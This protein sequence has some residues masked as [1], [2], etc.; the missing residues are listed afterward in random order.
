M[1][2]C[3]LGKSNWTNQTSQYANK[4]ALFKGKIF[5]FRAYTKRLDEGFID[6]SYD[7]GKDKLA[8]K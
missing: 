7:W 8:L 3:Y 5:D 4:D 2:N 6:R 1:T